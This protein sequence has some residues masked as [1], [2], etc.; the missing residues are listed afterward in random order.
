MAQQ[1]TSASENTLNDSQQKAT[2][3]KTTNEEMC[4]TVDSKDR[5]IF[6]KNQ[7]DAQR[8]HA[9]DPVGSW[10]IHQIGPNMKK[11]METNN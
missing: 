11:F 8:H 6:F 5:V 10:Q 7:K 3:Q 1:Q 4:Y 9:N 2:Q